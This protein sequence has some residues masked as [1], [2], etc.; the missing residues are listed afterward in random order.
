MKSI[1]VLVNARLG[2]SR[3]KDKLIRP[4]ASSCL[5]DIALEKLDKLDFFDN[6]Y[7]AAAEEELLKR[8]DNFS[9]I[10]RLMRKPESV[11]PGVN[12]LM[13]TFGHYLDIPSDYIFVMNPCLPCL[14][15][16]TIKKAYEYF[17]DTDFSSYT[18]VVPTG[19]WIFNSN[20][21]CLTK[22][23][24]TNVTTNKKITH[25]KGCHAFHIH[26]KQFIRDNHLLWTF[27]KDDPRM[28]LIP[29]EEAYDVDNLYEFLLAEKAYLNKKI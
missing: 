3:L 25:Y 15:I 12:P 14:K 28:I 6:R 29:D 17:Q 9:N 27:K 18:S 10:E 2:S 5:I 7:L 20:S 22:D 21:V 4:F 11:K 23:D 24:P 13:I 19:D 26:T 1:S 16:S 8:V